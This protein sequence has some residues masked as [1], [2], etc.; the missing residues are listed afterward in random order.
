MLFRRK[1]TRLTYCIEHILLSSILRFHLNT[2]STTFINQMFH[3]DTIT[4]SREEDV[5][6]VLKRQLDASIEDFKIVIKSI[7][8]LLMNEYIN[9]FLVINNAKIIFLLNLKYSIYQ[10]I[11]QL[12][13]YLRRHSKNSFSV[14]KNHWT[15]NVRVCLCRSFYHHY[16]FVLCSFHS[17]MIVW[18]WIFVTKRRTFSLK[19]NKAY[20]FLF[21]YEFFYKLDSAKKF[22]DLTFFYLYANHK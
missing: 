15:F 7:D 8:L 17:K 6:S 4:T 18:K 14:L 3:F 19:I 21:I 10:L 9:H 11:N 5:Y 2:Y 12:I 22:L 13:R 1:K 20:N 16:Q